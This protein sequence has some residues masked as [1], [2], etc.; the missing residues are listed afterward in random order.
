M[1]RRVAVVGAGVIGLCSAYHLVC[2]G[3]RVVVFEKDTRCRATTSYGNAG[4]I[5]PSH[6]VPLSAPG[7]VSQ[8]LRWMGDP[9]SPFYLKPRPS[10]ELAAWGYRFWRSATTTQV[11]RVAP[12]LVELNLASRAAYEQ[13]A[14]ELPD[15]F[16]LTRRG[17]L[18]LSASEHGH[19]EELAQAEEAVK[20]GLD[21]EALDRAALEKLEPEVRFDVAGAVLYRSDAH[22]DP[23]RFMAALQAEL[24]RA[25]AEFRWGSEPTAI[26]RERGAVAGLSGPGLDEEFDA[27]VLAGGS[28]SAPLARTAGVRLLLQP[29]K[30][31][32]LTAEAGEQRLRTPAILSEAR[33][34][35]TPL[36]ERLRIGGTMEL[37]GFDDSQAERRVSG[38][39]AA[40]GRYL[41]ELDL[42][43]FEGA[44]RWHGFRPCSPDGLPYLGNV[45]RCPGLVIATG[46]AMMGMSLAP[47]T[48]RLVADLVAQRRP[49]I[50]I[51]ALSPERHTPRVGGHRPAAR[52]P[53]L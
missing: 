37:A 11:R 41:P 47:V 36:G 6:F 1:S 21:V 13:L 28:W 20:L 30:G 5:V 16:G 15:D 24:E 26:R 43:P 2:E 14:D 44:Q 49:A 40:V 9:T 33:V 45:E 8:A 32:S 25:G 46:H 23:G 31:Y 4:M 18:M 29:G 34:A 3:H 22:L 19:Q 51:A 27:V 42:A 12:L 52:T 10:L 7:V 38:I 35:V 48:G 17:L 39:I 53:T 50:Q